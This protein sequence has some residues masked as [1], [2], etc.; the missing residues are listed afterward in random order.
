VKVTNYLGQNKDCK[1]FDTKG[2]LS[3]KW[4]LKVLTSKQSKIIKIPLKQCLHGSIKLGAFPR[5]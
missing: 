2:N 3:P 5:G 4:R 1:R